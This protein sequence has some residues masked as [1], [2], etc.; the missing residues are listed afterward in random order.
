[1]ADVT[2]KSRGYQTVAIV[3]A[4]TTFSLITVILR[5]ITRFGILKARGME[6]VLIVIAMVSRPF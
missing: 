2:D 5:C 3:V 1:M 4:F 6:D